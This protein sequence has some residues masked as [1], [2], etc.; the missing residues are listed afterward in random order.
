MAQTKC[1]STS[2][3]SAGLQVDAS[4]VN[5]VSIL[6]EVPVVVGLLW[7]VV[8]LWVVDENPASSL[9]VAGLEVVDHPEPVV[10][11]ALVVEVEVVVEGLPV[12]ESLVRVGGKPLA[13]CPHIGKSGV[14][15]IYEPRVDT[16]RGGGTVPDAEKAL[17]GRGKGWICTQVEISCILQ[18][19][20]RADVEGF[21]RRNQAE[22]N[23]R[24]KQDQPT[25]WQIEM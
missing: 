6:P 9:N 23:L 13:I 12:V 10:E 7:T 16:I 11:E 17:T 21:K 18:R 14:V 22:K 15:V 1:F 25:P 2:C 24:S 19:V 4:V 3:W 20:D 8:I 5:P